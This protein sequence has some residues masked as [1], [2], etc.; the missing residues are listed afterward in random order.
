MNA[1]GYE[2]V[3]EVEVVFQRVLGLFRVSDITAVANNCLADTAGLLSSV[4]TEP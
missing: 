3:D 4:D 2:L 1:L